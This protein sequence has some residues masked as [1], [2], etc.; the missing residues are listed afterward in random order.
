MKITV[1]DGTGAN[2][3]WGFLSYEVIV[4]GTEAPMETEQRMWTLPQIGALIQERFGV[5]FSQGH[6]RPRNQPSRP[7]LS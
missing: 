1:V 4:I 6:S 2:G 3:L 7:W 5:K